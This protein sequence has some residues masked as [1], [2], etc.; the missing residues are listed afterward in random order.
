MNQ[1]LNM[2]KRLTLSDIARLRMA[3]QQISSTKFTKPEEIVSWFGAMQAQDYPAAKWALGVRLPGITDDQV[4]KALSEGKIVRSWPMRGTLHFMAA[5]DVRWMQSLL[6]PRILKMT[7]GRRKQMGISEDVISKSKALIAKALR[8]GKHLTSPE[9]MKILE[10]SGIQTKEYRGRHIMFY[11]A[12]SNFIC[13]GRK[14]GKQQTFVLM[15]EWV[16]K[17]KGLSGE[18]ALAELARRYFTSHGPATIKDFVWWSGLRTSDARTGIDEAKGL[19][20]IETDGAEYWLP[21]TQLSKGSA[22]RNVLLLPGFD[23]YTI[24][25]KDRS[26]AVDQ[27]HSAALVSNNLIFLPTILVDGKVAGTWKRT[28]KGKSVVLRMNH[29][30]KLGK[31]ESDQLAEAA[32]SYGRFLGMEARLS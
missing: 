24:S 28:V 32:K 7:E 2:A 12:Q 25:Y 23:E 8:G 17:G 1:V 26:A 13:F 16:P 22:S 11:L 20:K 3:N 21:K 18:A 15:D 5:E 10:K 19:T 9:L 27:K 29:F 30:W 14:I 31:S 6:T 4:E